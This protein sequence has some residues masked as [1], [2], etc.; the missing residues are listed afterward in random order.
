MKKI[1]IY[2]AG[3]YC[4]SVVSRL[5]KDYDIIGIAD[6]DKKKH[7]NRITEKYQ[8]ISVE[9]MLCMEYDIIVISVKGHYKDIK[10]ELK[11]KNIPESKIRHY[12]EMYCVIEP[13][14]MISANSDIEKKYCIFQ[15]SS[16]YEKVYGSEKKPEKG[17]IS[18]A[19]LIPTPI[20]GSGGH[21][22][23]F[24]AIYYLDKKG[25]QI[26]V[27]YTGCAVSADI[28]KWQIEEWFYDMGDIPFIC[29]DGSMGKHDACI[30]TWWETAYA[31]LDHKQN[32]KYLFHF[33][34]DN[35]ALFYPMSSYA[36]LAEN[37]YKQDF[38]YICSGPWMK[39]FLQKKY[40]A[41]AEY[42][43]FPIDRGIYNVSINR[44][45]GNKNIIFFAKPEMPR[46]CFEIGISALAE[47]YRKMPEVEIILFG[48]DKV[49]DVPFPVTNMGI[50]PTLMDLA[51]LY[52]NADLGIVF[53]TTNPSLVPYE[54]MHCGCPVA[55][56]D[57]ELALSKYGDDEDNVFLLDT[58]PKRMGEQIC[59]IMRDGELLRKKCEHGLAWASREFPSEEEMGDAVERIILEETGML[60][61]K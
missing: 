13:F 2:G 7:G 29:Y 56:M 22:N 35:E 42:F 5:A 34:Q 31:M 47:V 8:V 25:Y 20:R 53:S 43:Q 46:R 6:K 36:I 32:F 49:G 55:D 17:N 45:K 11:D 61:E 28:V 60:Y 16:F 4:T 27:Y 38:K 26:T 1:I 54:M 30:A 10:E 44:I 37:T 58:R 14:N 51:D 48:S 41:R 3:D 39:A 24:R 59:E 52:R 50:L 9:E 40:H 15:N 33:V 18:I 19:F 57:L 23:I 12:S 21:R